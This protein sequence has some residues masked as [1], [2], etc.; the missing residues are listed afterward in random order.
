MDGGAIRGEDLEKIPSTASITKL[1]SLS[2]EAATRARR[3]SI[4]SPKSVSVFESI[5][6]NIPFQAAVLLFEMLVS[7]SASANLYSILSQ[8]R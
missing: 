5:G 6:R 3:I 8:S 1:N 4:L 2:V 7:V